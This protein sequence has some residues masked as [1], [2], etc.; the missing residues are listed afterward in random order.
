MKTPVPTYAPPF[1]YVCAMEGGESLISSL[2]STVDSIRKCSVWHRF[3][4][5]DQTGNGDGRRGKNDWRSA[6]ICHMDRAN[7]NSLFDFGISDHLIHYF[8]AS[9]NM[10]KCKCRNI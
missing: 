5:I 1:T 9:V 4:P 6:R 7:I 2:G 8:S 3:R 10:F